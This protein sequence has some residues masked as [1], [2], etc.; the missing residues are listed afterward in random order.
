MSDFTPVFDHF[1]GKNDLFV[2]RDLIFDGLYSGSDF[3]PLGAQNA[4]E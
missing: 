2:P 1:F 4:V 3:H